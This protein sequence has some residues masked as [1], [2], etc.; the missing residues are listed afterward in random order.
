MAFSPVDTIID[1]LAP[2]APLHA[3]NYDEA[4]NQKQLGNYIDVYTINFPDVSVA[5]LI[6]VG[7]AILLAYRC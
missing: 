4:Y 5:D 2:V 3:F 1:F 7:C 6:I